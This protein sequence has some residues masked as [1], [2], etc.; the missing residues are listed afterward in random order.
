M[1]AVKLA[2]RDDFKPLPYLGVEMHDTFGGCAGD[3]KRRVV[4]ML[5]VASMICGHCFTF[6]GTWDYTELEALEVWSKRWDLIDPDAE[7][8]LLLDDVLGVETAKKVMG[9]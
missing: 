7:T 9:R 2:K 5:Q 6:A 4:T 3:S 1:K 8:Q